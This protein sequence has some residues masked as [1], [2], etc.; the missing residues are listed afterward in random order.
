LFS[1]SLIYRILIF[2]FHSCKQATSYE[3]ARTFSHN[4][5]NTTFDSI[6]KHSIPASN[7]LVFHYT[8]HQLAMSARKS[9]I[10]AQVKFNGIPFSLRQPHVT[11]ES[12]FEVFEHHILSTAQEL[13]E[14]IPNIDGMNQTSPVRREFP[15][16]EVLVLSLPK[17]LLEPL[18]GYENDKGLCMISASVL[19]AMRPTSF[20]GVVD[21]KPW[22]NGF[23]LLPPHC[24]LRSFL[25]MDTS[26]GSA[27]QRHL[28]LSSIASES[29]SFFSLLKSNQQSFS[30]TE[31][32]SKATTMDRQC[33]R[34]GSSS[35]IDQDIYSGTSLVRS[36][37]IQSSK[38]NLIL[39]NSIPAYIKSMRRI[40]QN[41]F[42]NNLIP[43]F[44]YT[45]SNVAE[46]ILQGGLRMSTQGQG[47]GGGVYFST[48]GPASYGLGTGDYEVNIIKDCFGVERLSEYE[49]KGKLDVVLVYGCEGAVLQQVIHIDCNMKLHLM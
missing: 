18:P 13:N 36:V 30:G 39:V 9:G 21:N 37:S 42:E 28:S 5:F 22:F 46:M 35:A 15:N 24:I 48:F 3:D 47:D 38:V 40:R 29:S 11:E 16:E 32:A 4:K 20:A 17:H 41:A 6:W 14:D 12:D 34:V 33:K 8:S 2:F 25:I 26:S 49:G 45:S 19:N 43:M 23:S 10:P 31:L 7:T 1:I 44:H 27:S